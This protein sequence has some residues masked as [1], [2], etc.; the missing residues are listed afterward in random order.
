[1]KGASAALRRFSALDG[2]A[3]QALR[4]ACDAAARDTLS[5]PSREE[6]I[7]RSDA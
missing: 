2:K 6:H 7:L 1:M 3:R 4:H 5:Q